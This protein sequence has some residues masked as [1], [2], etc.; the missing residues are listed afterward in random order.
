MRN[1]SFRIIYAVSV[2]IDQC[3]PNYRCVCEVCDEGFR[4]NDFCP[5]E[6]DFDDV[7]VQQIW[8]DRCIINHEENVV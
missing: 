5:P 4:H 7:W 8:C 6:N 3:L 1:L 2:W